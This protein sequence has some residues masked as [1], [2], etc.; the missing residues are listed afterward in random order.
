[1]SRSDDHNV[2]LVAEYT[3][4]REVMLEHL[5]SRTSLLRY[6]LVVAGALPLVMSTAVRDFIGSETLPF[7]LLLG[8]VLC[9]FLGGS[10]LKHHVSRL[11]ISRYIQSNLGDARPLGGWETYLW[12]HHYRSWPRRLALSGLLVC[13]E[14]LIPLFVA[15]LY[16]LA[17]LVAAQGTTWPTFTRLVFYLTLILESSALVAAL[18][19]LV[20]MWVWGMRLLAR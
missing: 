12:R 15:A 2:Y 17:A 11:I 8:P 4:L 9:M 7:A 13:W 5:R 19:A 10:M 1:M 6:V 14:Y 20:G 16:V 3:E 18:L